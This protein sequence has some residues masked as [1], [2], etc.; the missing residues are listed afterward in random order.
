MLLA[1]AAL[2]GAAYGVW[3]AADAE[4]GRSLAAQIISLAGGIAAGLAVY[5]VMVLVLEVPEA[6]QIKR[7]VTERLRRS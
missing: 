5:V 2:A 3:Y 6:G 4:L 7:L 1:A